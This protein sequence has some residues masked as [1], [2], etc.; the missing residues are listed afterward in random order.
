MMP[1]QERHS[2]ARSLR[3]SRLMRQL[4]PVRVGDESSLADQVS[5]TSISITARTSSRRCTL[6]VNAV[7][8]INRRAESSHRVLPNRPFPPLAWGKGLGIG[9]LP[10]LPNASSNLTILDSLYRP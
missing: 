8:A 7:P 6:R 2:A 4:W 10:R 1:D 3:N 9:G 5:S